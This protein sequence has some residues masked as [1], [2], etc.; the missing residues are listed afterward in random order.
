M[1][2]A[3]DLATDHEEQA[4]AQFHRARKAQREAQMARV[5]R[6]AAVACAECGGDIPAA[7]LV[8]VPHARHCIACA[9]QL[10]DAR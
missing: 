2:D 1:A 4:W 9:T 6:D 10:E 3:A 7:R 5:L 8:A